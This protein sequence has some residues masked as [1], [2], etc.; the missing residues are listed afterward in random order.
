[1]ART[2]ETEPLQKHTLFLYEGDFAKLGSFFP[3]LGPSVAVRRIVR[4]QLKR[5]EAQVSP[6]PNM[7]DSLDV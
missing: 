3:E 1:M 2:L 6:A 4:E 5:L 7:K